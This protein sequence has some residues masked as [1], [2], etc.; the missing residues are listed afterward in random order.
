MHQGNTQILEKMSENIN[1]M[2][3]E[4]ANNTIRVSSSSLS[5]AIR[6]LLLIEPLKQ[7]FRCIICQDIV[8]IT[9]LSISLCCKQIIACGSYFPHLTTDTCPHCRAE[10]FRTIEMPVFDNVVNVLSDIVTMN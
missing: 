7:A 5:S 9:P 6:S 2:R 10:N 3:E 4:V 1:S 8:R